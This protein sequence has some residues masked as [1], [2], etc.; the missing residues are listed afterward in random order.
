MHLSLSSDE[1]TPQEAFVGHR[2]WLERSLESPGKLIKIWMSGSSAEVQGFRWNWSGGIIWVLGFFK[3]QP[4]FEKHRCRYENTWETFLDAEG[5][6][7]STGLGEWRFP[8]VGC[9]PQF[10]GKRTLTWKLS[11]HTEEL[12]R[13]LRNFTI[14]IERSVIDDKLF[15]KIRTACIYLNLEIIIAKIGLL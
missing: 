9:V 3:D 14:L 7:S 1:I 15:Y 5:S 2:H 8:Q 13:N 11:Y 6:S 4:S 10:S 12:E